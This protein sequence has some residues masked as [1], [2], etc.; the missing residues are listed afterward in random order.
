MKKISI[1][2]DIALKNVAGQNLFKRDEQ[3][4]QT[5][6]VVSFKDF[7]YQRIADPKLSRNKESLE[8]SLRLKEAV[9]DATTEISLQ[10]EDWESFVEVV[11]NPTNPYNPT[12]GYCLLPFIRAVSEPTKF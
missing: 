9:D 10:D 2:P 12:F 1:Q 4:N 6:A 11:K 3:G 7:L 8:L 5:P